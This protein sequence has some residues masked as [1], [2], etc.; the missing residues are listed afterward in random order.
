MAARVVSNL[1]ECASCG[2]GA[3]QSCRTLAG[4][5]PGR[6]TSQHEPRTK[7]VR[8]I[9]ADFGLEDAEALLEAGRIHAAERV[10][11]PAEAVPGGEPDR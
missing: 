4:R 10:A 7:A 8:G 1:V 6:I 11:C 9:A 2:A 3:G 5:S